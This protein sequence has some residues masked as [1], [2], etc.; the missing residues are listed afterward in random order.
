MT[1][2][3][4]WCASICTSGLLDGTGKPGIDV[5]RPGF[6]SPH[7]HLFQLFCSAG[8]LVQFPGEARAWAQTIE[9]EAFKAAQDETRYFETISRR[10]AAL[11]SSPPRELAGLLADAPTPAPAPTSTSGTPPPHHLAL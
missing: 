10:L 6:D 8:L 2:S 11:A 9:E 7:I 5:S 1:R 4:R 3:G